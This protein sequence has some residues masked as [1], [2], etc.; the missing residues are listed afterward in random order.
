MSISSYHVNVSCVPNGYYSK[1]PPYIR[2]L[3][4]ARI[5]RNSRMLWKPRMLRSLRI[6]RNLRMLS[7]AR[8]LR[9]VR[10]QREHRMVRMVRIARDA[11]DA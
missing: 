5:V 6:A 7:I 11:A 4:T 3:M 9:I 1:A 10:M 2:K 8:R